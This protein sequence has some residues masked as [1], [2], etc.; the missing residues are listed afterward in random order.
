MATRRSLFVTAGLAA[1][2]GLAAIPVAPLAL[3]DRLPDP[4]A[5]HWDGGGTPDGSSSFTV[6]LLVCGGIWL[7]LCGAAVITGLGGWGRRR[8]RAGFGAL[9]GFGAGVTAG[10]I[11]STLRA[12]LDRASW[13]EA[14]ELGG[15]VIALVMLG[16]AAAALVGWLIGMTGSDATAPP[17]AGTP[18]LKVGAG[19]RAVWIGYVHNRL[20]A[21]LGGALAAAGAIGAPLVLLLPEPLTPGGPL[22]IPL[23]TLGLTGL[24][25][26][27]LSSARVTVD[28]RG[29][30]VAFG[31]LGRPV[32]RIPR[33]RIAA[34]WAEDRSPAEAGGWGY[35][36]GPRGTTVMLRGGECLVVQY[37]DGGRFAVSVDD[38]ERGAAL[39]NSLGE[40][41]R[42]G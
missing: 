5:T 7:V 22:G 33:G 23:V 32:R 30:A 9:L 17:P 16:A 38:A 25:V 21:W 41:P 11:G 14:G 27:A 29:L 26:L 8:T 37:D 13:R 31:P 12:N 40:G 28:T 4:L 19:Q 20:L 6:W 2:A 15:G 18:R 1:S 24:V 35:R 10:M 42:T 3:R 36:L 39:L 34:A